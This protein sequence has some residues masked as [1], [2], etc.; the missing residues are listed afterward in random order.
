MK[1]LLREYITQDIM[2]DSNHFSYCSYPFEDCECKRPEVTDTLQLMTGGYLD[3]LSLVGVV[4]FI[5]KEFD[6]KINDLDINRDNFET[7]NTMVDL[8]NRTKAEQG[9]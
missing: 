4:A 9:K 3:S 8:I 5:E 6:I 7:I 1:E 2:D